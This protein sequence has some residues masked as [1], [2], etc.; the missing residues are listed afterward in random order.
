MKTH[1]DS[2]II[3]PYFNAGCLIVKPEKAILQTWWHFFKNIHQKPEFKDFYQH[4]QLYRIFI[5]Q[6]VLTGTILLKLEI[7]EIE[8]LPFSYNYPLHL[9]F[10]SLPEFRPPHMNDLI[11]VRYEEIEILNTFPLFN[12]TFKSWLTNIL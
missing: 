8:E 12:P 11:T 9:Y 1:V 3:R 4:D 7:Q 6:A 10:D 2:N 5:H